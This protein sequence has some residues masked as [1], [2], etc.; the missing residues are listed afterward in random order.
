MFLKIL[1]WVIIIASA[2]MVLGLI[3]TLKDKDVSKK[4][5]I[6]AIIF[7]LIM[8]S[9]VG[10]PLSQTGSGDKQAATASKDK[11]EKAS[12]HKSVHKDEKKT[13][14]EKKTPKQTLASK[15]KKAAYP[16]YGKVTKVELNDYQGM[17]NNGKMVLV[18][19]R[20]D[21]ITKRVADMYSAKALEQLFKYDE[22]KEVCIFW[23][24]EL[25]DTSGKKSVDTVEK[26]DMT[27][28]TADKITW[29]NFDYTNLEKVAD[30]YYLSPSM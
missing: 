9:L 7:F 8:G 6:A 2:I 20:A 19:I 1:G 16:G 22:V 23:R 27:R 11:T 4:G 12:V 17:P 3:L 29:K 28:K 13:A 14:P 25:A 30:T 10:Y 15:I 26:V 18:Y 21:A 5:N 24:C